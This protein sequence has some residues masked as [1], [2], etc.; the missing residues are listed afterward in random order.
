MF[1]EMS[2]NEEQKEVIQGKY[3]HVDIRSNVEEDSGVVTKVRESSGKKARYRG[4]WAVQFP[5][6]F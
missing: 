2:D 1:K 4:D 3:H 5:F 6:G